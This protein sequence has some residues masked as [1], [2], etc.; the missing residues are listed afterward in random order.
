[1]HVVRNFDGLRQLGTSYIN[2]FAT[3]DCIVNLTVWSSPNST[4]TYTNDQCKIR[5]TRSLEIINLRSLWINVVY[6]TCFNVRAMLSEW[7]VFVK[8]SFLCIAR[9]G[10]DYENMAIIEMQTLI[11]MTGTSLLGSPNDTNT[12][13][14]TSWLHSYVSGFAQRLQTFSWYV[15]HLFQMLSYELSRE[16]TTKQLCNAPHKVSTDDSMTHQNQGTSWEW[17]QY[18]LIPSGNKFGRMVWSMNAKSLA[19]SVQ[20]QWLAAEAGINTTVT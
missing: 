11:A 8:H 10:N 5:R 20:P 12:Q 18:T 4:T 3:R 9:V 14:V 1:M 13:T 2:G 6:E 17:F 7:F 16:L 19:C 15:K